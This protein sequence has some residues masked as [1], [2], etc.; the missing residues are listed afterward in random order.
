M[1]KKLKVGFYW[2]AS[3]GGCEIAV[4][5]MNEAILDIIE[6]IDIKFWPVAMD[7]KYQDIRDMPENYF[8]VFLFNG[9]VRTDEQEELAHLFRSRSKLLIAFGSCAHEGCIPG[10]ANLASREEVFDRIY[11]SCPSTKN[12][13]K[14]LPKTTNKVKEGE[15]TLPEFY[16]R[17]KPL[18]KITDIDYYLP[19]CPPPSDLILETLKTIISGK[20]LPTKK[21]VLGPV[22]TLCEDCERNPVEEK[23]IP[24]LKDLLQITPDR[25]K[26]FLEQGLICMGPATRSGCGSRCING[27]F[28]CTGCMGAPPNIK[29]Q[30][31]KMISALTSIL[32]IDN[33]EVK[34]EKDTKDMINKIR[35]PIGTFYMYSLASSILSERYEKDEKDSD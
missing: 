35:D 34:S 12:P 29:D 33:E 22:H 9:S 32:D 18:D 14:I 8:D 5:D 19:G 10:L 28:P 23:K 13:H 1:D 21:T 2:A 25:E 15:I 30:G 20:K 27:N 6:K 24:E 7:V 4:L 17:V 26:C 16:N 31:S 11:L 3:C